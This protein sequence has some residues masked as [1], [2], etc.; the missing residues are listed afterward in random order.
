MR[1]QGPMG[2]PSNYPNFKNLVQQIAKG[3]IL[4]KEISGSEP[5]EKTLGRL[6]S[7]GVKVHHLTKHILIN[8]PPLHSPIHTDILR[9]FSHRDRIQ[10]VTTNFDRHFINF[11]SGANVPRTK[12][13]DFTR[14]RGVS[15]HHGEKINNNFYFFV[16]Q[17]IPFNQIRIN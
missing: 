8:S 9:L 5:F 7:I 12:K 1:F 10:L 15:K 17:K 3:T 2:P 13:S 11:T 14:K 6:D 4:E 16:D